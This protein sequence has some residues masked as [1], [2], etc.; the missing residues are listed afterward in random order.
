M[1]ILSNMT[2]W[3]RDTLKASY[4]HHMIF[5]LHGPWRSRDK[6]KLFVSP[7]KV[8][9]ATKLGK[10]VTY[11]EGLLPVKSQDAL[12]TLSWKIT[13]Q[14]KTILFPLLVPMFIKHGRS[15]NHLEGQLPME[16]LEPLIKRSCEIKWQTKTTHL[17]YQCLWP[18]NL[19]ELTYLEGSH[20]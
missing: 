10:M 17:H 18:P 5:W 2:L 12:T 9:M 4:L 15:W 1:P 20:L 8:P 14:T 13:W 7:T 16:S 6:L 3:S 11:L 19:A